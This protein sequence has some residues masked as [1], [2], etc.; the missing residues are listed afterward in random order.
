MRHLDKVGR[1]KQKYAPFSQLVT[2]LFNAINSLSA[3]QHEYRFSID[4]FLKLFDIALCKVIPTTEVITDTDE[5]VDEKENDTLSRDIMI[6]VVD[7]EGNATQHKW[8]DG[9]PYQLLLYIDGQ[10]QA[11]PFCVVIYIYKH[12]RDSG[13]ICNCA[14]SIFHPVS[15]F[16]NIY[17]IQ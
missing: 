10:I 2:V 6:Q 16:C 11:W 8:I 5:S 14:I 7:E 12:Y 4:Y 3:L 13:C 9:E 17:T 15:S 1:L